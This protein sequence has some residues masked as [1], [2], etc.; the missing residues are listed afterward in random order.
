[1]KDQGRSGTPVAAPDRRAHTTDAGGAVPGAA[2]VATDWVLAD[3]LREVEEAMRHRSG[4]PA[5]VHREDGPL[6]AVDLLGSFSVT[7]DDVP[8]EP[9]RGGRTRSLFAFL[10]THRHP[11]PAR[12]TLMERFWSGS[13]PQAA[14]NSLNVAVHGLRRAFRAVTDRP[15]I[16]FAANAYRLHP[17]VRVWLDFEEFELRV[18]DGQRLEAIGDIDG[19]TRQ[20]EAADGLYRG[21]FLADVPYED[22][23]VTFR[24]RLRLTHLDALDRLS[25]R[26]FERGH[27]AASADL[28]ARILH[29][30]PCR[31]RVHRR[32][33]RCH[34]RQGHPHLALLQHRACTDVLM[35]ELGVRPSPATQH[36]YHRI[37]RHEPV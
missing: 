3:V 21:D 9:W 7:V 20:Y 18:H 8:V 24:D 6:L 14:R 19:A 33:M 13:S 31:E 15:V 37:R 35:K 16:Q 11:W 32:L 4:Q 1:M 17:A 23:P 25:S 12:E 2:P 27:Y 29:N 5:P 22:W 30:D 28:C 36:L 34:S 26:Y 10:V